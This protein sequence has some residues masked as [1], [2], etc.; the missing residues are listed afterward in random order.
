MRTPTE[1]KQFFFL[2][3]FAHSST[4][5]PHNPKRWPQINRTFCKHKLHNNP[6]VF[7]IKRAQCG[8]SFY[9]QADRSTQERACAQSTC[10]YGAFFLDRNTCFDSRFPHV[11]L[12]RHRKRCCCW[13]TIDS[14]TDF[15]FLGEDLLNTLCFTYRSHIIKRILNFCLILGKIGVLPFIP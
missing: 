3:S 6:F 12:C 10:P 14:V 7:P 4:H 1:I 15:L 9:M 13:I 8:R 11:R 5:W 2:S